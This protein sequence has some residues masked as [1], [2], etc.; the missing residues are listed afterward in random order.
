M[1]NIITPGSDGANFMDPK[2]DPARFADSKIHQRFKS[3]EEQAKHIRLVQEGLRM[4]KIKE[5]ELNDIDI[6]LTRGQG[7]ISRVRRY[8]L[9]REAQARAAGLNLNRE[10]VFKDLLSAFEQEFDKFT[11]DEKNLLLVLFCAQLT[12]KEI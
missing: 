6:L 3:G 11:S 7:A 5:H 10:E 4:L 12:M 1:S 2:Y 9:E 8:A